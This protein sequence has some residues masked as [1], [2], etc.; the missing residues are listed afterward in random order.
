MQKNND[1][2]WDELKN[3]YY[4]H[5]RTLQDA[6]AVVNNSTFEL[7]RIYAE[8]IK[9]SRDTSPDMMKEFADSWIKQINTK[10]I[11]PALPI[12]DDC[13][14][15]LDKPTH[16]NYQDFGAKLQKMMQKNTSYQFEAYQKAMQSFYDTW[17]KMWSN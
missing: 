11:D 10:S 14:K 17:M 16:E 8:V 1:V 2:P 9:K 13:K 4:H 5:L 3:Q 12:K 7:N 15:L 6:L